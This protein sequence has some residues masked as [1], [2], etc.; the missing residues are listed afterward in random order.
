MRAS[1]I[2]THCPPCWRN[3]AVWV[4]AI[5]SITIILSL[6]L[7]Q[8]LNASFPGRRAGPL[9]PHRAVGG[10]AHHDRK[11]LRLD[12]RLLLRDPQRDPGPAAHHRSGPWTGSA[13]TYRDGRHDRGGDLRLVALHHLRRPRRA[14]RHSIRR[15]RGGA[16]GRGLRL[17]HL[18][19]GD[20]ATPAP[21][22]P[23]GD[24]AE[25]HLR[26]QLLSHR[27]DAQRPQPGVQPR[28]HDHATCTRSPS[29]APLRDV[30]V[31]PL[32]WAW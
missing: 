7:G 29:R 19:V 16:R 26:L 21:G 17:A 22:P 31:W 30:G 18:P 32:P 6:G 13:M 23:R 8:F 25:R 20:P 27:V 11:A 24:R 2:R 12:L 9:G 1:S 10:L 14:L 28:H 15:L 5:V 4:A 3:T